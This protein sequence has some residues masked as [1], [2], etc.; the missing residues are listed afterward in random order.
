MDSVWQWRHAIA[1]FAALLASGCADAQRH[2]PDV[3]NAVVVSVERV[4]M[5]C[6]DEH[7][8]VLVQVRN[9]TR[10]EV[11]V[12]SA[13]LSHVGTS[14]E[15]PEGRTER[16][17]GMVQVDYKAGASGLVH[18]SPGACYGQE[19]S[20]SLGPKPVQGR[21]TLHARFYSPRAESVPDMVRGVLT[22]PA[23]TFEVRWPRE[24]LR[25]TNP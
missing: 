22:A 23:V 13:L 25:S 8:S 20:I 12:P 17:Q 11:A 2:P 4:P 10:A 21:W 1:I 7:F 5:V 24:G 3:S 6:R 16:D 19:L 14:M 15:S 9:L 18:L